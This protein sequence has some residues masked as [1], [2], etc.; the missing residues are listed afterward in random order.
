MKKALVIL[1]H[2]L[3][4]EGYVPEVDYEFI[5]NIH[6]EFQ[7]ECNEGIAEIVGNAAVESIRAA[8]DHF[9]FRC[10]LDGEFKIGRNWAECH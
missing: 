7:I 4:S 2:R 3:Q 8:G 10:P 6:D 9:G 5:A 1:D